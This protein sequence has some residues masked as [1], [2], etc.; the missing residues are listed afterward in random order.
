MT[1]C[2]TCGE[3]VGR[4]LDEEGFLYVAR[5][6]C[7]HAAALEPA[8]QKIIVYCADCKAHVEEARWAQH[9]Q[10]CR[11]KVTCPHCR[12]RVSTARLNEHRRVCASRPVP[13]TRRYTLQG[14]SSTLVAEFCPWCNLLVPTAGLAA[15]REQ[16]S[17]RPTGTNVPTPPAPLTEWRTGQDYTLV[18]FSALGRRGHRERQPQSLGRYYLWARDGRN[19]QGQVRHA[20]PYVPDRAEYLTLIAA[21]SDLVGKITAARRE[22]GQFTLTVY[23][24][25]EP[26]IHQLA[27]LQ[28]CRVPTATKPFAEAL[29]LL[30]RFQDVELFCREG[31]AIPALFRA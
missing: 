6:R 29:A 3:P 14:T 20:E 22:P 12:G 11:S 23:S 4:M 31:E 2:T 24:R 13:T 21:L 1:V 28:P 9:K 5:C 16:C 27:G 25:R 7:G 30:P 8:P 10:V 19:R 17:R 26:V 18:V 15:H